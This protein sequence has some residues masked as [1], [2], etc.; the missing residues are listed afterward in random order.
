MKGQEKRKHAEAERRENLERSSCLAV[1]SRV[2][3]TVMFGHVL[4][5]SV[6]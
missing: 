2:L 4:S 3:H 6:R 1:Y 5:N